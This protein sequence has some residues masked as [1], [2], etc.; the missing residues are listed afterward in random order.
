ML[1]AGLRTG[2]AR[3]AGLFLI[4]AG[5]AVLDEN[6]EVIQEAVYSESL[7]ASLHHIVEKLHDGTLSKGK[8]VVVIDTSECRI[9]SAASREDLPLLTRRYAQFSK[10]RVWK[11][12]LRRSRRF[13]PR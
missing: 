11:R 13:F 7:L 4:K 6:E 1:A 3:E 12:G 8:T 10:R 9:A 5:C 2:V